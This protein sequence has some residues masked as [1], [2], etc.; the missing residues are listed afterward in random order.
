MKKVSLICSVALIVM[1]ILT[2]CNE[3]AVNEVS[4]VQQ[5]WMSENLD[6]VTFRNGDTIFHAETEEEWKNARRNQKP[7]WCF[8]ENDSQY[9]EK[10]GKLYNWFAV[11]D[12]RNL[13]PEGWKI[14]SVDDWFILIESLGENTIAANKLRS[15]LWGGK[16][17]DE[18]NR[19]GFSG[20]PGGGRNGLGEFNDAYDTG[21]W[22]AISTEGD[23]N[24]S[25]ILHSE[26]IY[27]KMADNGYGFSVRCLKE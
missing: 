3:E 13:A 15:V 6:V 8:Y 11:S 21:I 4:S 27:K 20:M 7:A 5:E 1:T 22:W 9:G 14:P 25:I 19:S 16:T 17:D 12:P 2:S 10:F 23:F 24:W 26:G 18:T